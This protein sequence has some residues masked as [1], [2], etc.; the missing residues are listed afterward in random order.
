MRGII[1]MAPSVLGLIRGIKLQTR[2][3][4]GSRPDAAYRV[5][6]TLYVKETVEL[7]ALEKQPPLDE[8]DDGNVATVVYAADRAPCPADRWPWS[9]RVLS[10][11]FMPYGL[12][13]FELTVTE[14]RR[15]RLQE[16]TEADANAEGI[17]AWDGLLDDV[18]IYAAAKRY[19]GMATD[20]RIWYLTA[21]DQMHGGRASARMN[22]LVDAYTFTVRAP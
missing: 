5:G 13:R 11:L 8:H 2:R 20:S 9:R 3:L 12:R 15:Q 6:E 17:V 18:K 10:P 1:M 21:W 7:V 19:G 22:P 16:I 14:V 4:P